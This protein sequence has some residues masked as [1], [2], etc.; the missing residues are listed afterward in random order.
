M[1]LD[2]TWMEDS[3]GSPGTTDKNQCWAPLKEQVS[4]A[5]GRE[6]SFKAYRLWESVDSV[7][8]SLLWT[9]AKQS[10]RVLAPCIGP[11]RVGFLGINKGAPS[12][13]W[14]QHRF[15]IKP[16]AFW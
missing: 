13:C 9:A 10:P 6:N 14:W 11:N 1:S 8:D 15:H 4:K 16:A 12:A 2:G 5:D 7:P 3:L